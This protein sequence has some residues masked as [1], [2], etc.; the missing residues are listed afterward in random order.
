[1]FVS[2]VFFALLAF[3]VLLDQRVR[4]LEH[5]I[6]YL[7]DTAVPKQQVDTN[8]PDSVEPS[9]AQKVAV[10]A[11]ARAPARVVKAP[12]EASI[13]ATALPTT[14]PVK[15]PSIVEPDDQPA[16]KPFYQRIVAGGFEEL[17][18]S[19]LPIW[20]G[21]ITLAVAGLFIVKY[22]IDQGL[23]SENVRIGL[24]L[25][26]ATLLIIAAEVSHRWKQT[27][28]DPRVA[29]ALSGAGIAA[30]Y[31]SIL[32]AVNVYAIMGS[33]P[34]F[35][36]LATITALALALS[37]RFGAPSAV[38]GLVGGVAA[39]AL[40]GATEPNIPL[41]AL[42]LILAIGG[43]SAV[44]RREKWGWLATGA[45]LGGFGWGALMLAGSFVDSLSIGAV[46]GYLLLLGLAVPLLGFDRDAKI[47]IRAV[48]MVLAALQIAVLVIK[49]G[50]APLEWSFYG[51]LSIGVIILARIDRRLTMMPPIALMV[52]LVTLSVWQDPN[53]L[54]LGCVVA[55]IAILFVAVPLVSVWRESDTLS[56]VAQASVALTGTYFITALQLPNET[57]SQTTWGLIALGCACVSGG[58]AALGWARTDRQKDPRFA[59]LMV[60]TSLFVALGL[61]MALPSV[62]VP[63]ALAA[64]LAALILFHS[65]RADWNGYPALGI[66]ALFLLGALAEPILAWALGSAITLFGEPLLASDLPSARTALTHFVMP[67]LLLSGGLWRLRH[68]LNMITRVLSA[69][70]SAL[71]A[72][73]G[74]ILF[75]HAFALSNTY[76]FTNYGLAERIIF[77]Q[78]LWVIAWGLW[79][80][81]SRG[82]YVEWVA[83]GTAA[84]AL[85]RTMVYDVL[86]FNPLLAEQAVGGLPLLNLLIPAYL[87]P[88]GWM[89]YATRLDA[90]L[91]TLASKR[92]VNAVAMVLILLFAFASLRHAFHGSLLVSGTLFEAE[93]IA[94]SLVAIALAI[95]FLRYGIFAHDRM[96]RIAS[97]V[98]ML[99]AVGKVFIF[100]ASGLDGL[101]RIGSFIALGFSLIGIGWLY[102]RHLTVD[103][104]AAD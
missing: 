91:Q 19:R 3:V 46:G 20:A 38:L 89:I 17:F 49:G 92:A 9:L 32:M 84:L 96:W 30:A 102:K 78:I 53:P 54:L 45:L 71:M 58:V 75:K 8:E 34:G 61:S 39:P 87:L 93:D 44:A 4:K 6:A 82:A 62:A 77:T 13:A 43:L 65:H 81:R 60:V 69:T 70:C 22:S 28:I 79:H 64:W 50:F 2:L 47:V 29:Q 57:F 83:I 15:S 90:R 21:G 98:L 51:L 33:I 36:S 100:D 40:V 26:F 88:L 80:Q 73:A 68:D 67:A 14:D 52:A 76:D 24:G 48:P 25:L 41:L 99:G 66:A 27:A 74:F 12:A 104:V 16:A 55:G 35:I 18:G 94:R 101:A 86:I 103:S 42:Y 97:L 95:G 31:G 63:S 7:D 72:I 23:L 56:H 10:I 59:I 37:L 11:Q 5:R 1:M 85:S